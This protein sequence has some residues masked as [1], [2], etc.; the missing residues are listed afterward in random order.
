VHGFASLPDGNALDAPLGEETSMPA[1]LARALAVLVVCVA[2]PSGSALA[3]T[4]PGQPFPTNLLTTAD[5]TQ[6]TGLRVDLPMPDC[7][8]RP[9]DCADVAVLNTLDGFNVQPRL[10]IPFS[11][12]IDVSTVSSDTVFLADSS[13]ARVGINQLV[14]Q[15]AANTLHA[16][17]DQLLRQG[18]TYVLVVTDGVKAA[19]G[20]E[21][22]SSSFRRDLN[23]GQTKDPAAKAYRKS[24]LAALHW[25]GVD[26]EHIVD[27][28]LFTTQSITAVSEK[29][30]RQIDASTP[31]PVTFAI[32][33]QGE[34]AVFS[35][36]SVSVLEFKRQ[37]GT[38]PSFT[39]STLSAAIPVV[40]GA[41]GTVAFGKYRSPDYETPAKIIPA[42]G[43]ATDTP[44]PQSTNDVYFNLY[45][46]AGQEPVAGWPVAVFGH[47]FT[48]SKQG[49][50][51][52]VAS[53][54]A[55]RGIATI[56]INVVG[57][58]GGPLGTLTVLRTGGAA[59]VTF[60]A[61]GRGIDQDGTGTIDST[62]GV[63]ATAPATL[64]SNR[65][66]LRQTV[67]DLMQL[68]REIEVGVDVDS[69]ST[70]DLDASRI[71]Y[72]GQSF[73][74]IYGAQFLALEPDVRQG[75]LNAPGGSI[76]EIA[77]LSPSFRTLVG[78]AL[79]LRTPSLYN[80]PPDPAFQN[81]VEN[82]PL[83]NQPALIDIVP[84]AAAIQESLDRSEW[85]QQAGNAVSYA[86]DLRAAPLEGVPAK[87]VIVQFAKGDRTVPNPT[88]SALI[89]AGGLADRATYFRHDLALAT[90]G[91]TVTNP[92]TFLTNLVGPAP[93]ALAVAAQL[94]I[95]T[96]LASGGA[97]TI[98]PDGGGPLFE[99]PIAGPLPETL[100]FTP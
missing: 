22:D 75:V 94:Q 56:A 33:T 90:P 76:T 35:F 77:R 52:F 97:T 21:L 83:R 57:H 2:W 11:G 67:V 60:P 68:V 39:T 95:A 54:M 5:S 47:A 78:L 15:P 92:H 86:P 8:A 89:R 100:N 64:V 36:S 45:L 85:A 81:F 69:D 43:T 70:P 91:Y 51:L 34:R 10:S 41:I 55:S 28:S 46:P 42:Y 38:E 74:G 49:A 65:D 29:I 66:G 25:S 98:D 99:T 72:F 87:A 26:P 71:S 3:A 20:S 37:T 6:L 4:S 82:V 9:S 17:S 14:W 13:G 96:F 93:A 7:T 18:T 24:L 48:D 63:N 59:P 23:F 32:G 44:V 31:A 80:V 62:E 1:S 40:P 27:A 73:G 30:R 16:E 19:D 61:G 79:L 84:G 88:A 12:P 58:G 50:P 53:A